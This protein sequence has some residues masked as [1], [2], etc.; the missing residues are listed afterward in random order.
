MDPLKKLFHEKASKLKA[1]IKATAKEH[2][3]TVIGKLP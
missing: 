2:G 3:A 1:E